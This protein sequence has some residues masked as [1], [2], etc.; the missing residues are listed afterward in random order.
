MLNEALKI[1]KEYP[2]TTV[3]NLPSIIHSL[4]F[5]PKQNDDFKNQKPYLEERWLIDW[6]K[7]LGIIRMRFL[8]TNE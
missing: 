7:N 1:Q 2:M 6:R 5:L 3:M 4:T 8:N